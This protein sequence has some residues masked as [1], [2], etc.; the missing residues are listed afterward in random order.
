MNPNPPLEARKEHLAAQKDLLNKQIA[1]IRSQLAYIFEGKEF[2]INPKTGKVE[3]RFGQL[4]MDAVDK[5][6]IADFE[7]RLQEIYKQLEDIK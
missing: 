2:S 1:E 3:H 7:K 6:F 5:E 4:E